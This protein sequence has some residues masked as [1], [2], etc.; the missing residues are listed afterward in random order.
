MYYVLTGTLNSAHSLTTERNK[1]DGIPPHWLGSF[2]RR[3]ATTAGRRSLHD[4]S[5]CSATDK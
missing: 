3:A 1:E 2:H 5:S 4:A